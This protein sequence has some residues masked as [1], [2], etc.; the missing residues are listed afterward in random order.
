MAITTLDQ[1]VAAAITAQ[2]TRVYKSAVRTTVA[3]IPFTL[4]DVA[5]LPGAGTLAGANTANGV[6]PTDATAGF[7]PINAF[8]VGNL[9]YTTRIEASNTVASRVA[10]Y[11]LLFKAGA[12]AFN[13]DT[14]LA[15]Q[16]SYASRC[17]FNGAGSPDYKG[18]ELWIEAVT[19]FTG[20]QTIQVNYLDQ[21]GNAGDTGAI[22]TGAAPILGRMLRLP[23]A[24]GDSGVSQITRVRSSVSTVGTF[25]VLVMRELGEARI[26]I[27]N[28]QAVQ[29]YDL[30][31]LQEL[32]A[33]SALYMVVT[34][35]STSSGLPE[36]VV[37]VGNG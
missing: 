10:I 22:A 12:Y 7:Y 32:F 31:G 17:T 21:D 15:S 13:A 26:R 36:I 2:R 14:T 33:D 19:A 18:T 8:G 27:A 5:G 25:N 16:P 24:A 4:F 20:N 28:D 3:N 37:D 34:P 6:V 9:G 11:D 1:L 35:D 23:L 30:T 29:G